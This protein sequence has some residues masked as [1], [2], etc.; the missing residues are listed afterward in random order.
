MITGGSCDETNNADST[1]SRIISDTKWMIKGTHW[2]YYFLV[3][4]YFESTGGVVTTLLE[5]LINGI[6]K[7]NDRQI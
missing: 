3:Y 1:I 2:N 4:K 7:K 5:R 6:T